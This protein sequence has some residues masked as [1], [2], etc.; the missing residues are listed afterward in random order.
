MEELMVAEYKTRGEM[1]KQSFVWSGYEY[2][3]DCHFFYNDTT[4]EELHLYHVF[5]ELLL[6]RPLKHDEV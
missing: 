1:F 3:H 6:T 2:K 5:L 4:G